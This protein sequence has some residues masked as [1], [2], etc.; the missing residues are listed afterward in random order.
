M[1]FRV[2]FLAQYTTLLA[3]RC[4]DS[5]Q[6]EVQNCRWIFIAFFLTLLAKPALVVLNPK[7][8]ASPDV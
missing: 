7:Y 1:N 8:I 6:R 2:I 4:K 5:Y 3:S